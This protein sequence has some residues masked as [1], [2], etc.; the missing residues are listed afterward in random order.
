M[1]KHIAICDKCKK[2]EDLKQQSK[3][4]TVGDEKDSLFTKYELPDMWEEF[5]IVPKYTLCGK[6]SAELKCSIE[7]HIYN[8]VNEKKE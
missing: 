7:K 8:F 2:E 1:I 3:W 6:C 5:S 4:Y